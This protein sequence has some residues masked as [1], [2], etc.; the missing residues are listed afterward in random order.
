[1]EARRATLGRWKL[2]DA[3]DQFSRLVRKAMAG[4]PQR[5]TRHG[6]DAVVVISAEEYD[7][8]TR[9]TVGLIEFL[10]RSPL[11]DVELDLSRA[12]DAGRDVDL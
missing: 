12:R 9:P 7:R 6:R 10:E 1:M 8:I 11:A 2:E 3:K 4:E 5:V